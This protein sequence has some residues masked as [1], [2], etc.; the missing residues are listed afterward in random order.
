MKDANDMPLLAAHHR[1][2]G[3]RNPWP[4]S[5]PHGAAGLIKWMLTRSDGEATAFPEE[6]SRPTISG[7]ARPPERT[8]D[9][10]TVTWVGHSSFLLQCR[11]VN[12]LTD[13]VWS[14]RVSP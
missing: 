7:S 11:G 3:F 13:P 9:R 10:L 8:A 4:G 2:G 14:D 1:D 6:R 12:I 5:A